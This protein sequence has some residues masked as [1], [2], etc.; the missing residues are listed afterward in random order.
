MELLNTLYVTTQRAYLHLD[1]D[2]VRVEL[3]RETILRV[4]LLHLEGL[5]CFGNVPV[6][7]GLI[8][9]CG[10]DGRAIVW[11]D[12][13]G[14][15][16][17]RLTGRAGGNVMLRR[18]QHEALSDP[19][20]TIEIARSIVGGKVQNERHVVQRAA[21][22]AVTVHDAGSLR[23]AAS[24]LSSS[25]I[26]LKKASTLDEVR[27]R[28]GE[29]ARV[30]FAV[31]GSMVRADRVSFDLD[32]RN[33]RPPRDRMNALLSFSYA[34]L[35]SDCVA[36]LEGVGLD[37]QVGYL[38]SLRAGRPALGLDLMEE[39]RPV[40]ADRLALS[41]VNRRQISVDDFDVYPGGGVL[42]NEG[43]RR[44][45]I[46]AYQKRKQESVRH[47]VLDRSVPFGLVPHLQARLLARHLRGDLEY[48]LPFR[49]R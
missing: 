40:V 46:A 21:R 9:R 37:H 26:G 16:K 15:F 7:P 38:H 14:H 45:V 1:H 36:A 24:S 18:A 31:F 42:L 11:L 49:V 20:R 22:E 28:E 5:V 48:Y 19:E 2:T 43:G 33:R 12:R 41:L 25:L 34:L 35:L 8:Q 27:G 39:F 32:G 17:G 23:G 30:Y 4:P 44:A 6:S 47:L 3:E 29:A 10:E 13:N